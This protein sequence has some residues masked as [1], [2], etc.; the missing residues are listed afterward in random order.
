MKLE[1][2]PENIKSVN[3][4]NNIEIKNKSEWKRK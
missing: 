4:I 2:T 1:H 3:D